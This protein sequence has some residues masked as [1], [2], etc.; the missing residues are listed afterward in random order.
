MLVQESYAKLKDVDMI[1]LSKTDKTN[2]DYVK[3]N[4][5]DIYFDKAV[6]LKSKCKSK[7]LSDSKKKLFRRK[8]VSEYRSFT[9]QEDNII[10]GNIALSLLLA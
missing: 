8:N 6:T 3:E 5:E 9:P 2:V 10:K 7:H 1:Y 4:T